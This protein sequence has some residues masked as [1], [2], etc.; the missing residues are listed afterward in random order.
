MP[1]TKEKAEEVIHELSLDDRVW[2]AS[3]GDL[4][5]SAHELENTS[6]VVVVGGDGTI[7]RA[8]RAI[9]PFNVP[10]V[11]IKMGKV[12]FMAELNPEEAISRLPE[13]LSFISQENQSET[14]IRVEE[15]MMIEANI[16]PSS[17]TQPRITVHALN[18]ITVGTSKA[19]RL[20]ELKASVN[21]VHLTNYR[22]DAV[23]ISTATGSTGYALSAG[24]PIVFP[25][26]QMMILQPVAAHTG[27]RD[28][29]ILAPDS[30][31]E[32]EASDGYQASISADG[33]VDSVLE[34]GEKVI[35][36]RSPHTAK[37]LRAHQPDFFYTALNMRLGLAYR[38]QRPPEDP[39]T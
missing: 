13:F 1:A 3:A 27:L 7:L 2:V 18:D 24:G 19:A 17:G 23:I 5:D 26:A 20:V 21:R 9:S 35:I 4:P 10:V 36:R 31:I 14:A 15:R 16:M 33:F 8:I 37:F 29:L 34:S 28:G 30:L 39:T 38:S 11:G 12:G 22:A 25:E 6:L 32:L